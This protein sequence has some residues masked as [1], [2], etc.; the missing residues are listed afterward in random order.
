MIIGNEGKIKM[1]IF[2]ALGNFYK[3]PPVA[4]E[5]EDKEKVDKMYPYWRLSNSCS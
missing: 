2:K 4:Q 5:I 3:E 1:N